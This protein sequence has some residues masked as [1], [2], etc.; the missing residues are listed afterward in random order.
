[1]AIEIY[2]YRLYIDFMINTVR[3]WSAIDQ[4]NVNAWMSN[5]KKISERE[6]E[7]LYKLLTN[8]LYFSEDDIINML[9]FG[10]NNILYKE[11][12]LEKELETNFG[13]DFLQLKKIKDDY[14][15]ETCF[16][17]LLF[18]NSPQESGNY[19]IRL[20]VSQKIISD[21]Q[22]FFPKDLPSKFN[23]KKFKK[24]VIVDDCIGSGDQLGMFLEDTYLKYNDSKIKL[25]DYC[26]KNGLEICY[27]ALFG[28]EKKVS[29][30]NLNIKIHCL[31]ILKERHRVFIKNSY[32]WDN[33]NELDYAKEF[34][35]KI[36]KDYEIKLSGYHDLDFALIMHRTIPDWSLPLFWEEN[37]G[38]KYLLRRK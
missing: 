28:Y 4:S 6:K 18:S 23:E 9:S 25:Q 13:L 38:W 19:I 24:V 11:E 3:H 5:F 27:M 22:A 33:I 29:D 26:Q 12:L 14:L 8:I 37:N 15:Q 20:L 16:I 21:S 10:V 30:N 7:L 31:K 2:K 1:M 34:F 35:V 17:P 36:L 32:I